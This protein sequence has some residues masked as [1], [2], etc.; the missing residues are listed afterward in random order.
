MAQQRTRS[1]APPRGRHR[2]PTNHVRTLGLAT[3]PF[4][5]AFPMFAASASPAVAAGSAWDRLAGCESG[6]N[7]GINTG[8]G[9]YGGLQFADG[10]WDG[11]G[12]EKYASRADLASRGEQIVI[13]AKVLDGRGWSPWPGC[14]S[15][16]GLG[17][18]E[19]REAL[20][21]AEDLKTRMSGGGSGS[22][23]NG[24]ATSPKADAPKAD[25][26]KADAPKADKPAAGSSD[27]SSA[28]K[29][30]AENRGRRPSARPAASTARPRPR[31]SASGA[32]TSCTA[33]TPCP[34][35]P[36]SGTSPAAGR[37]STG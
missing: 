31:R 1:S 34:A 23:A 18:A 24:D 30:A 11:N 29:L 22:Q 36:P 10:T 9:Y 33:A 37:S 20:A 7:W 21:T 5:A 15:R 16:L 25:A 17:A 2:K 4:V 3:A 26:P 13:A 28:D 19:R 35:S 6:G 12:G 14:S 27:T 32:P 8:N